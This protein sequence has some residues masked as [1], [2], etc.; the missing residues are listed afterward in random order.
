MV[1]EIILFLILCEM[2]AGWMVL[3]LRGDFQWLVTAQDELPKLDRRAL[4]K[5]LANGFDPE[6]GW[7]RKPNSE[8][9]EST[10]SIG[11]PSGHYA[12]AAYR[13][14]QLGARYNPG[15]EHLPARISTYGDSFVF[16]RQVN[17][18]Q[19][20]Q[21]YLSELTQTNA[22]NFGV[23]NYGLDQALLRLKR[24]YPS[25]RTQVVILGVVPETIVRVLSVWK[26]Y[27]EYGN[28]FGFKPR[29]L[30]AENGLTLLPN[31]IDREDKFY[32]LVRYLPDIQKHDYFYQRKFKRHILKF[33]YLFSILRQPQRNIP[34]ISALIL[35]KLM[36]WLGKRCDKP[37]ELVLKDNQCYATELYHVLEAVELMERL[38]Q[39]FAA[40]AKQQGFVPV[41][42]L[43]PYQSDLDY[44]RKRGK[45]YYADFVTQVSAYVN[46]ID[47]A[48]YLINKQETIYTNDFYGGHLNAQGNKIV[49][50][51]LYRALG[52]WAE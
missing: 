15:H 35:R 30:V 48:V 32:N 17:D 7:V 43:L 27:Y 39:E 25:N 23:G 31:P 52:K 8:G 51:E 40:Y 36:R 50:E 38:A 22:L 28:T 4:E 6:L 21:W 5:F 49:A 37:W 13:I 46:T 19:T 18:D 9:K 44:I 29:F 45:S 24:E 33:P 42:L 20:W 41:F 10:G 3:Y 16:S 11:A 34:L 12:Q 14:N 1:I 47:M 2:I 26:H